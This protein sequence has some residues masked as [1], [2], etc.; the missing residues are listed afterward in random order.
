MLKLF[1]SSEPLRYLSAVVRHIRDVGAILQMLEST[2]NISM[3]IIKSL[4]IP[5]AEFGTACWSEIVNM[6]FA[7]PLCG[8]AIC[9]TTDVYALVVC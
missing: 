4:D 3:P 5:V 7:E 8:L 6:C 9:I 2:T 1:S